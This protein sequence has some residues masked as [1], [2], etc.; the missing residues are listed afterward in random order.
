MSSSSLIAMRDDRSVSNPGPRAGGPTYVHYGLAAAKATERAT[1][2][3]TAR[4]KNPERFATTK[5]PK[6]LTIPDTAW[7]NKPAEKAETE[8]AA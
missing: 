4:T 2:L 1:V 8:L 5:D 3:A 7:I 6:I